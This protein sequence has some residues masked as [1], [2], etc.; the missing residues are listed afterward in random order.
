MS[1]KKTIDDIFVNQA[2]CADRIEIAIEENTKKLQKSISS[3]T[4]AVVGMSGP[5]TLSIG[6]SNS[7]DISSIRNDVDSIGLKMVG[8]IVVLIFIAMMLLVSNLTMNAKIQW[9]MEANGYEPSTS[10]E[11]ASSPQTPDQSSPQSASD[12]PLP[13][14]NSPEGQELR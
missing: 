11:E 12:E 2:V 6:S 10:S 3:M 13:E 1:E 4:G 7:Y 14:S 9:L 5:P 8:V